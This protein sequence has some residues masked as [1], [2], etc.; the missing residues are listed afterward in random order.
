MGPAALG[1]P[2]Y[3][4]YHTLPRLIALVASLGPVAWAPGLF[5][6]GAGLVSSASLALLSRPGFRWSPPRG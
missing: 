4:S 6:L 5:A 2:V 3:G 1:Q